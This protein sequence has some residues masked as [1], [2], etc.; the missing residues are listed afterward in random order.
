MISWKTVAAGVSALA[1]SAAVALPV[2]A[3]M[4]DRTLRIGAWD[5]APSQGNPYN[6]IGTPSVFSWT[7]MFDTLTFVETDGAPKP[8]LAV[9]WE[10]VD[11][12]TWRF[13]LRSGVKFHNGEPFTADAVIKAWE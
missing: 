9:G 10:N 13:N 11:A 5:L 12:T 3:Q 8:A 4:Q 1:I 7:P 6:G 2:Q